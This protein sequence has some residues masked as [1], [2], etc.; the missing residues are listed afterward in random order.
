MAKRDFRGESREAAAHNDAGAR[1]PEVLIDNEHLRRWPT[2]LGRLGDQGVL[3][4]G[5]FAIVLDLRR[6][7]LPEIDVSDATQMAGA[8]LGEI[9][10]WR[11]SS[12]LVVSR[13]CAIM[14]ARISSAAAWASGSSRTLKVAG[15]DGISRSAR[16]S[17]TAVLLFG[18]GVGPRGRNATEESI[19]D[20]SSVEQIDK[21]G[22]ALLPMIV[23]HGRRLLRD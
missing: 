16:V 2:E 18:G 5:G 15:G 21:P 23:A 11:S 14:R 17:C 7:G 13:A 9:I 10:H 4:V 1:E 6:G 20:A 19:D 8:D 12:C 3:A 22:E